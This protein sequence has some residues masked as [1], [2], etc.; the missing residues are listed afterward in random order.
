MKKEKYGGKIENQKIKIKNKMELPGYKNS[1]EAREILQTLLKNTENLRRKRNYVFQLQEFLSY[2]DHLGLNEKI[3]NNVTIKIRI[4]TFSLENEFFPFYH[5]LGTFI[6]ELCHMEVRNHGKDFKKLED[7]LHEEYD[8]ENNEFL[9]KFKKEKYCL[10]IKKGHVLGG[11][12]K[13]S[14]LISSY[15]SQDTRAIGSVNKL[16][17]QTIKNV[18]ANVMASS[19]ALA[20]NYG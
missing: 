11:T 8:D 19:A 2:R 17:G 9:K 10:P 18:P 13:K 3:G 20:R 6:H 7:T 4:R 16:G 1:H 15:T 5:I 12:S 14:R